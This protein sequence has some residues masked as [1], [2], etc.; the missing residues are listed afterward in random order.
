MAFD[1]R[2]SGKPTATNRRAAAR[3]VTR[4]REL[5]ADWVLGIDPDER[6]ERA[7]AERIDEMVRVEGRGRVGLRLRE[8]Y[9]PDAYR[10]DG[11]CGGE[12]SVPPLS[13]A[14]GP[15]FLRAGL[16]RRLDADRTGAPAPALGAQPLPSEND[17]AGAAP[18]RRDLYNHVDPD[19]TYQ[20]I[21]YDYLAEESGLL[22]ET[23]PAGREYAPPHTD[24]GRLWMAPAPA[25]RIGEAER[26]TRA[27]PE[28]AVV[29]MSVGAPPSWS[30]RSPPRRP[31]RSA[32]N[33]RRQFRRRRSVRAPAP[34]HR[35]DP[36]R[37]PGGAAVARRHAQRRHRRNDR[38][39]RGLPRATPRRP[40]GP[41]TACD[42]IARARRRWRPPWSSHPGN[43]FAT[44]SHLALFAR[45]LP[46]VPEIH[47]HRYGASFA[48]SL[49]DRY[50]RFREDLRTGEDTELAS[51]LPAAAQPRWAPGCARRTPAPPGRSP[52]SPTSIAA[53]ADGGGPRRPCTCAPCGATAYAVRRLR[54]CAH[55]V[56]GDARGRERAMAQCVWPLL[57]LCV[58]AYRLGLSRGERAVRG[59][60]GAR[61]RIGWSTAAIVCLL[62]V[63][64][65]GDAG[66]G[67]G[68]DGGGPLS[69]AGAAS[70]RINVLLLGV[71]QRPGASGPTR[72][73]SILL[74]T[75]DPQ[76]RTAGMLSINRD[77]W[78]TLPDGHGEG[79][80]NT[81]YQAGEAQ[82]R[83]GGAAMVQ[84]TVE[85]ALGMP[86]P[87]YARFDFAAF[88][89]LIDLIGGI[90]V[91]VAETI[92]DPTFPD[93]AY[94][95][96]PFH[97]DAGPQH[98]TGRTALRYARTRATPGADFARAKRQQQVLLAV[99]DKIL[100]HRLLPRLLSQIVVVMQ[101]LSASVQTNLTP[102]QVY[103]LA[104][105]AGEIERNQILAV[106]LD[107]SLVTPQTIDGQAVLVLNPGVPQI[108]RQRLYR[109]PEGEVPRRELAPPPPQAHRVPAP[110]RAQP[111]APAAPQ[112]NVS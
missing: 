46:G 23:I 112:N 54:D 84:R 77:L 2:G 18:R 26:C 15:A 31:G 97:L 43:P 79:R 103:Q 34:L 19:R 39:L 107:R 8:L 81:A 86:V 76:A 47:A 32:G 41:R 21:G 37:L 44:A 16:P 106:T 49:F 25:A 27:E 109:E 28:L 61:R 88:E 87:Y 101:T 24:D 35:P 104:R 5:G 20:R 10:V 67:N 110:D 108:L 92:D 93:D 29:V 64:L 78:V 98:L 52:C 73:D 13:A 99:R 56:A 90:D 59:A 62:V 85:A 57:A 14:A 45:R 50:G 91:I 7:A 55:G 75:L 4:A 17:R 74:L 102:R 40:G 58:A 60:N 48:R 11:V 94:G 89:T 69:A 9:A 36:H 95:Y 22:L 66:R 3:E 30:A 12:R 38:A 6:L 105:L 96:D 83:G 63:A 53:A 51:R 82:R 111:P 72:T 70:E 71:D 1:D 42:A 80:I 100:D 65:A 33:R 68:L